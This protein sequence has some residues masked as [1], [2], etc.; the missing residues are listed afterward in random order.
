MVKPDMNIMSDCNIK[1]SFQTGIYGKA[2]YDHYDTTIMSDC[3]V[4]SSFQTGSC[5]FLLI[6]NAAN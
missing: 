6:L 3:N 2:R 5:F 1:T 4:K